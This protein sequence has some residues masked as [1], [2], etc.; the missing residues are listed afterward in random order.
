MRLL[1]PAAFNLFVAGGLLAGLL[2]LSNLA[3]LAQQ[4]PRARHEPAPATPRAAP[5]VP[6]PDR[7]PTTRDRAAPQAT[8]IA[9]SA[10]VDDGRAWWLL[11]VVGGDLLETDGGDTPL[12]LTQDGAI[13]QPALG[14]ATL[15][16]VKRTRNASDIWLAAPNAPPHPITRDTS[17]VV[18]QNHWAAQPVF[19]PG[20]QRLYALGDFNKGTTGVGDLAIWELSVRDAAVS[21]DQITHPPAYAGGDQDVALNPQQPQQLIFTRYAY[22]GTRLA[23]QLQ[24]LDVASDVL[25]P[26]TAADQPARQA[27]YA[28]DGT[29]VA[30]VQHGDGAHEDL[31]VAHLRPAG[32]Q[33]QL[34]D[35]QQVAAGLIANPVWRPD[36]RAL[37]YIA[38]TGDTFQIWSVDLQWALDG[39]LRVGQPRQMTRGAGVDATS[40]PVYLS[41]EQAD[42]V[43][44][45]LTP[46]TP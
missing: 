3:M 22:I 42:Q 31:Y 40:R 28:P 43:Q 7:T 6:P 12:Q 38:Q 19:V 32:G 44:R 16:F 4:P 30:F 21:L 9:T 5:T 37:A 35:I 33:T 20:T 15:A 27:T 23:E 1:L 14:E 24:W 11:Y 2:G 36:G 26:L 17:P 46:A 18:A 8:L 39:T 41:P 13:G 29:R 45:W 25:V 34:Q 10:T